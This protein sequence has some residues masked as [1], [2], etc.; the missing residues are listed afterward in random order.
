MRFYQSF[1][2]SYLGAALVVFAAL[3]ASCRTGTVTAGSG[4]S[5]SPCTRFTLDNWEE[6]V[7]LSQ[8]APE[9]GSDLQMWIYMHDGIADISD[10]SVAFEVSQQSSASDVLL[11]MQSTFDSST[12][13]CL[14]SQ[15]AFSRLQ[16]QDINL[17]CAMIN[18]V[19]DPVLCHSWLVSEPTIMHISHEFYTPLL[20]PRAEWR[21]ISLPE[22]NSTVADMKIYY[23]DQRWR[24]NKVWD[25]FL[26]PYTGA[27]GKHGG[28]YA[29][30]VFKLWFDKI[31]QWFIGIAA[32][33]IVK[34][35][36]SKLNASDGPL[37]TAA[38]QIVP[39]EN[40]R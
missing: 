9:F 12:T 6:V 40:L 8:M 17:S 14:F 21:R 16:K 32:T 31:P 27:L 4:D 3:P 25:G 34:R 36:L 38:N 26:H 35:F 24:H 29:W 19:E 28:G 2:S 23:K 11:N 1:T 18:C 13:T 39:P 5:T 10:G 15:N 33:I 7:G 30:G 20:A 22:L 37:I